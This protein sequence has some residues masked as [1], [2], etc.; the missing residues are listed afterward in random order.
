[1]PLKDKNYW[2]LPNSEVSRSDNEKV[3]IGESAR[4][5]GIKT[6]MIF[7][8]MLL[9]FSRLNNSALYNCESLSLIRIQE[10]VINY[11]DNAFT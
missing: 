6:L 11:D 4:I 8:M 2:F 5:I 3:A 1:M 7:V 10:S 9:D